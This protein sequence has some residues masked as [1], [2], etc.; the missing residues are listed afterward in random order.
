[1]LRH[2]L[3]AT[4]PSPS[5]RRSVARPQESITVG[6]EVLNERLFRDVFLREGK[7]THRSAGLLALLLVEP[8]ETVPA[9]SPAWEKVI[10]AI[11]AATRDTDLMGW[12]EQDGLL[13]VVLTEITSRN[14]QIVRGL[15]ARV[16]AELG[17]RMSSAAIASL[18]LRVHVHYELEGSAER[19]HEIATVDP[20]LRNLARPA[21]THA[22]TAC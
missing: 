3:T 10:D 11:K 7:R 4:R 2:T 5:R 13:G 22:R 14:V 9:A 6:R 15:E 1:M 20:L 21:S 12:L 17:K 16:R 19:K 8:S 18:S